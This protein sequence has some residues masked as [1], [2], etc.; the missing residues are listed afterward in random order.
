MVRNLPN[1]RTSRT[2]ISVVVALSA[3]LL[4][5]AGTSS[6]PSAASDD[7]SDLHH[8]KHR[9]ERAIHTQTGDIDEVST[10]LFRLKG[11]LDGA[12]RDLAD[13]RG[14]LAGVRALV[15]LAARTDR[16]MQA[17]L[18]LAV[19]RLGDARADLAAG[20]ADV[21][22][23]RAALAAYAVSS[24]QVGGTFSLGIAFDSESLHDA[25]DGL[26]AT[27]TVLNKQSVALQEVQAAR[28]LLKLTVE[29]VAQAKQAVV[30]QRA[31][32]AANLQTKRELEA[33]AEAA[34]Q[35]VV[36]RVSTLRELRGEMAAAKQ[37]EISRLKT[38]KRERDRVE[39]R[40]RKIAERRARQHA[41]EL[42]QARQLQRTAS[43]DD[44]GFLSYPVRHTYVTSPYGMRMHPILRVL[45]LHDGTDFHASCGTPVY[46]AAD[47]RVLSAYYSVGYG[48]RIL[49]DHGFV[50]GV[51]LSTT[52]NHLATFAAGVGQRVDRGQVIG[53]SGTTGYSTACHLHFMVDVNGHTVDPVRW[54]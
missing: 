21:Q 26:Q 11:R 51:S 7:I 4:S 24:S 22:D 2:R 1:G 13:A 16:E 45:K 9:L 18:T 42:A 10:K 31:V 6:A 52:Y 46:A 40:L 25:L 27:D 50:R 35:A 17:R 5:V 19:A 54:L 44:D 49:I 32:A 14:E 15:R 12:V 53:Y 28:V 48:N 37:A 47:G 29:R 3:S 43:A 23:N 33:Q 41:R 36:T 30:E 20:R 34:K 38:L 39:E 8:R